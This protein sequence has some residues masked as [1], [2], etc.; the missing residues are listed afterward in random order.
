MRASPTGN[1]LTPQSVSKLDHYGLPRRSRYTIP[2]LGQAH[3]S[4]GNA[5]S[6]VLQ[7]P[8]NIQIAPECSKRLSLLP[9]KG[10]SPVVRTGESPHDGRAESQCLAHPFSLPYPEHIH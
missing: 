8:S 2:H 4:L 3:P 7:R 6:A 1:V 5:S 9:D 10:A